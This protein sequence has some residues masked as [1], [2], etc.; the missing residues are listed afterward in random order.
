MDLLKGKQVNDTKIGDTEEYDKCCARLK[1]AKEFL[2]NAKNNKICC[3]GCCNGC[4]SC[5][6]SFLFCRAK[7]KSRNVEDQK[8]EVISNVSE[9]LDK[10][11]TLIKKSNLN[12]PSKAKKLFNQLVELIESIKNSK[13]PEV[14]LKLAF[15]T[16]LNFLEEAKIIGAREKNS[17]MLQ[18][19]ELSCFKKYFSCLFKCLEKKPIEKKPIEI[20]QSSFGD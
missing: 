5:L 3:D 20:K 17:L 12:L 9:V 11:S 14:N 8:K 16:T 18:K 7:S 15:E 1:L 2:D 4:C 6:V 10:F 13:F 19:E